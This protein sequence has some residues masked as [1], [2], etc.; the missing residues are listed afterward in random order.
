MADQD[1][2]VS[3]STN[4]KHLSEI[5][6]LYDS[7]IEQD[8]DAKSAAD[9]IKKSDAYIKLVENG[10]FDDDFDSNMNNVSDLLKKNEDE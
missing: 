3:A 4:A 2:M 9:I 10:V 7:L 1:R 6:K 5:N 8:T